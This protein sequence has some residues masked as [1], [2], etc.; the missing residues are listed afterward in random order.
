VVLSLS[1]DRE[2]KQRIYSDIFYAQL[3]WE[4]MVAWRIGDCWGGHGR[5][6]EETVLIREE[7][8]QG[9]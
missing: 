7:G 4:K 1:A 9:C 2:R 8:T 3:D 5:K 6:V